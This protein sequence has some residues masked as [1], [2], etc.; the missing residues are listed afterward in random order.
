MYKLKKTREQGW[1]CL[2]SAVKEVKIVCCKSS[3]KGDTTTS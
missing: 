2:L 1:K 3:Q